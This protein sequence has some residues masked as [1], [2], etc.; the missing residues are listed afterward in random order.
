MELYNSIAFK[1]HL[2]RCGECIWATIRRNFNPWCH[3]D[4]MA[5]LRVT[6][7]GT[8]LSPPSRLDRHP[9]KVDRHWSRDWGSQLNRDAPRYEAGAASCAAADAGQWAGA[10]GKA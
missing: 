8:A 4:L 3:M 1:L 7:K 10:L 5:G 2:R 9:A 6:P